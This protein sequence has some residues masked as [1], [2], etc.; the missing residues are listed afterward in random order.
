VL[1]HAMGPAGR[2]VDVAAAALGE[3]VGVVGA[4]VIVYERAESR[5]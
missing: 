3:R 2:V 1:E 4:A 5:G